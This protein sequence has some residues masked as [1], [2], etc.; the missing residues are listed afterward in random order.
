M[1]A[2][3]IACG[4]ELRPWKTLDDR[5]T[6][7]GSFPLSQCLRCLSLL[8]EPMPS[9]AELESF[10]PSDYWY[11]ESDASWLSR[12]EWRYRRLVL[13]D[14]VR[15]VVRFLQPSSRVLDVGCGSGTFLYLVK[16]RGHQVMGLDFSGEAAAEA[17]RRYGLT[18]KVGS[19]PQ[20]LDS[21]REWSPQA[22]T[23]F[24]VLEHLIDPVAALK[25]IS[26]VLEPQG[27]LFVQVP[28]LDSWQFALF[29]AR[30]Y[31]LDVPRHVVNYTAK[32]LDAVMELAGFRITHRKRFSFRD[33]SP[34]WVSSMFLSA[35]PMERRMKGKTSRAA[36][37]FY[38][39]MV[40]ALQPLSAV[41]SLF[42]AGG[43]LFV[44]A[45]KQGGGA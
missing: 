10:Y 38:A 22:A 32:G 40:A 4:G 31:G 29:G 17:K 14:H 39:A 6:H 13:S 20:H 12:L 33:N 23:M 18:V 26:S 30:W 45:V 19:L 43:T 3:C 5:R 44:R 2:C 15:F 36:N 34:C 24:H 42:G 21:L 16:Q 7:L 41:E 28:S 9:E 37:L 25:Q 27:Q 35:D 11:Q 8:M 1:N